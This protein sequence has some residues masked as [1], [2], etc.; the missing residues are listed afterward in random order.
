MFREETMNTLAELSASELTA[1]IESAQARVDEIAGK[2]N[3]NNDRNSEYFAALNL[4]ESVGLRLER[5]N[6]M[7]YIEQLE[8]ALASKPAS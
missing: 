7:D 4:D 2:L 8:A 1:R 3:R 6:W 5:D